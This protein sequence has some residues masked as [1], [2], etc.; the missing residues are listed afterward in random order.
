MRN[1]VGKRKIIFG[2]EYELLRDTP[3]FKK[4]ERLRFYPIAETEKAIGIARAWELSPTSRP[5]QEV[6][7]VDGYAVPINPTFWLPKS[8][9]VET[10]SHV[11]VPTWLAKKVGVNILRGDNKL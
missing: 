7:V 3:L 6:V 2:V 9:I 1:M 10:V 5:S 4:G 11:E 8:Q